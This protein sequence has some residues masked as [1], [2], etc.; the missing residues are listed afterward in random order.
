MQ[1]LLA[2]ISGSSSVVDLG[3]TMSLNVHLISEDKVLRVHPRFV[4]RDRVTA[5]RQL[6]HGLR[7]AGLVVGDPLEMHGEEAAE[8][9]A[10]R[11]AELESFVDASKPDATW[12]SYSW[13]FLAMGR[14]HR[15][16]ATAGMELPEPLVATWGPPAALRR[17]MDDT[18]AAVE[19]DRE[20]EQIATWVRGLADLLE[21][22]WIDEDQLPSQV[23]HGDVRLGNVAATPAG[24]PAY[25]DFGFAARRPRVFDLAY[26]LSWIVLK[27]DA[28]GR[29][30]DFNWEG[31]QDFIEAYENGA[32]W[33]LEPQERRALLP[34][35]A[36]VPLYLASI[37]SYTPDPAA[38]IKEESSFLAIAEWALRNAEVLA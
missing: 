37:S 30:D 4:T 21:A 11:I 10:G 15:V 23:I 17:R 35:L 6:R 18:T 27:P 2:S 31:V 24:E 25:F 3:G 34:Y 28:S 20:A 9:V 22:C 12:E 7:R 32:G 5:L 38:R 19:G 36:S 8:V 16:V 29:A 26:A 1:E 33:K 14:L 13:M